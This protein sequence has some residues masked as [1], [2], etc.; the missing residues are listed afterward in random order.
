MTITLELLPDV[1]A[2]LTAQAQAHGLQLSA[3]LQLLLE[4]HAAPKP[5]KATISLEELEAR[6]DA[7]AKGSE[8][9][10]VLPPEATTR[11]GLYRD[12]D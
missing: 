2:S 12:H 4:Q 5:P 10:P 9:L 7:L 1:E 3:Y 11:E 8:N 6:L